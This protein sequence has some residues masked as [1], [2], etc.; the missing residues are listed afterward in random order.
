MRKPTLKEAVSKVAERIG[1]YLHVS[2]DEIRIQ[3]DIGLQPS[4]GKADAIIEVTDFAFLLEYKNQG[5]AGV[6][7]AAIDQVKH[8]S[9]LLNLKKQL[10]PLI[11][12]PYMADTG[13]TL[14]AETRISWIDLSG[15]S[16]IVADGLFV[17]ETGRSNKFVSKGRPENLFSE[18]SSRVSKYL[19]MH[20]KN[21]FNQREISQQTGVDEGY[22]SKI[23]ARLEE[24][25]YIVR[26]DDRSVKVKEPNILLDAWRDEYNPRGKD[27]IKGHIPARSGSAA[28]KT[29]VVFFENRTREYAVT[30]LAAAWLMTGFSSFRNVSIYLR[31]YI[32]IEVLEDIGFIRT[33]KGANVALL[34]GQC[35]PG[36]F[37]GMK[38]WNGISC[39]HPIQ[40]YLDLK[41]QPER[42]EEAAEEL[43]KRFLKWK[44]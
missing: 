27:W 36:V 29:L 43:K 35:D 24:A 33:D 28:M 26:N 9:D 38:K 44:Q 25:K 12:V 17:N 31:D 39:V 7:S 18:V 1:E 2:S 19:L 37:L 23:C 16:S 5:Y 8:Y 41:E 11:V 14:C 42:S 32:Q 4:M 10:I 15:N 34:N 13:R 21:S 6:I 3:Y 40:V 20:P 22:V 30:G